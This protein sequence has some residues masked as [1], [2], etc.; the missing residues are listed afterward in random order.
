MDKIICTYFKQIDMFGTQPLFTIR[1][2]Q[3]FQT[4]AGSIVTL[5]CIITITYYF[6]YFINEMVYHKNPSIATKNYNNET[7]KLIKLSKNNFSFAFGL[8]DQE[9]TNY[10]DES[11][12]NVSAV[13][14]RVISH[15]N[16]TTFFFSEPI[17]IIKCNEYHF[18]IIPEQYQKLDLK[19]LYCLDKDEIEIEGEYK[20]H[21]WSYIKFNFSKCVNTTKN[22]FNC[23]TNDEINN[24]LKGGFLGLFMPDYNIFPNSYKKPYRAYIKNIY[25]SFSSL[26]FADMFIYLKRI[27]IETDSGYFFQSK[28]TI[29]LAVYD[30]AQNEIDYRN[31][32]H[33]LS[34]TLRVSSETEVHIRSYIKLQTIFSNVGGM[35]KMILIIGD[36]SILFFKST[37]YKN[38]ILEFFNL[39][40]SY[41]R[42]KKIRKEYNLGNKSG[43]FFISNQFENINTSNQ[44][45][46]YQKL[47]THY[48]KNENKNR[49]K[50]SETSENKSNSASDIIEINNKNEIGKQNSYFR[51]ASVKNLVKIGNYLYQNSYINDGNLLAKIPKVTKTI[52][53]KKKTYNPKINSE[54]NL[55]IVKTYNFNNNKVN[56]TKENI[57][58]KISQ[59]NILP[60]LKMRTIKV[61]HFFKDF[62]CKKNTCYTIKQVHENYKEIQFLLDIVH[63]LKTEN[64]ISIIEKLLFTEEQR[65]NLSYMYSFEADFEMEKQGYEHMI[66]HNVNIYEDGV[67]SNFN[68]IHIK[69]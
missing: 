35:L 13:Y 1:G 36:Y 58:S 41:I 14:T 30:Y 34:L 7:P 24:I 55:R 40:E 43:N 50:I 69:N 53:S 61:P 46:Y 19:N 26:Y 16:G 5:I 18:G 67:E 49:L 23:K 20:S 63:Y 42:I 59:Q 29:T 45:N 57:L 22:N 47:F 37:L 52:T 65:K 10:I 62:F 38:Y 11:I 12:Y 64:K 56:R 4:F 33:F 28:N 54:K 21:I 2:H 48:N 9:Y 3:T 51:Q 6:L 39:D 27:E 32:N 60:K 31:A 25:R 66:K 8:Q 44:K 68:S 15:N 17:N